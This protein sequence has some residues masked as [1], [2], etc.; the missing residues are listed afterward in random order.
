MSWTLD[1]RA[2]PN[3]AGILAGRSLPKLP[4][5]RFRKHVARSSLSPFFEKVPHIPW[6]SVFFP[7]STPWMS[8]LFG[9]NEALAPSSMFH[10]VAFPRSP[11]FRPCANS[12]P[13]PRIL[14][15]QA[16]RRRTRL[17]N[18]PNSRANTAT[19]NFHNY[20]ARSHP[21]RRHPAS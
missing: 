19:H 6:L 16:P 13:L 2:T 8:P 3:Q 11:P 12:S 5:V 7:P 21:H 20:F 4:L 15:G 18:T 10:P 1:S 17:P 9:S 14:L